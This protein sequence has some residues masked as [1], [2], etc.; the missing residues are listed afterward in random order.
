M[1]RLSVLFYLLCA[2]AAEDAALRPLLVNLLLRLLL[3]L[4]L[5][6]LQPEKAR[7]P[8]AAT[9]S[10]YCFPCWRGLSSVRPRR[11]ESND[12]RKTGGERKARCSACYNLG[13]DRRVGNFPWF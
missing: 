5:L 1:Y 7:L 3:R 6:L 13:A 2:A 12:K 11:E 9:T 4:L 10:G 8:V